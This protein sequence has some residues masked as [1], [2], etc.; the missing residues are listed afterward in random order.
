MKI[1]P[2]FGFAA[3]ALA[4]AIT[5]SGLA[6]Q[7]SSPAQLRDQIQESFSVSDY[8]FQRLELP[9]TVS[10][11]FATR[12]VIAGRTEVIQARPHS[13][14]GMDYQVFVD[15]GGDQLEEIQAPEPA[16]FLGSIAGDPGSKVAGTLVDGQ[17]QALVW[18]SDGST[19]A[20]QPL[21]E[22]DPTADPSMHIVY[23][24]ADSLPGDWRC[25]ELDAPVL[26]ERLGGDLLGTGEHWCELAFDTDVEFFVKNG[27][28]VPNTINDVELIV[29]L[30]NVI[31]QRDVDVIFDAAS[32]IVRTS[33]PD[34]YTSTNPNNLLNSF[35]GHWASTKSFIKRDIAHLMTGKNVDGSTIG[36]AY[37]S[38]VCSQ[39]QGFGL[40]QSRFTTN[41]NLRAGLTA[42]EIG[43]NFSAQHCDGHGAQCF[44]MCS[45]LGGCGGDVTKFGTFEIAQIRP[46]AAARPCCPELAP[47]LTFPLFDSFEAVL[48]TD[49]WPSV[50]GAATSTAAT[51]EVNGTQSLNLDTLNAEDFGDDYVRSNYILMSGLSG[52][53]ISFHSEHVGV[54]A[55]ETLIV[56]Y[57]NNS[58]DWQNAVTVV[59]DGVTQTAF[60]LHQ[61]DLPLNAYHDGFRVSFRVNGSSSDD[62]WYVD[63]FAVEDGCPTPLNYCSTSP[64]SVG[65]GAIMYWNGSTSVSANNLTISASICPAGQ[66]GIFFYGPN[67]TQTVFGNGF[68]CAAGGITR[69]QVQT[70]DIFGEAALAFDVT[71]TG[72]SAGDSQNFQFWYRDPA[73]GGAFFNLSDG[74]ETTWCP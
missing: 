24:A 60:E 8:S 22:A 45:G 18:P 30:I 62:D 54:E 3:V 74:L 14:R 40:S 28:S 9:A 61:F 44:I 17:L 72:I 41:L 4:A 50:Q 48:D 63:A 66:A 37:L 31:Y 52:K 21:T 73:G 49:I 43:H 12:V 67:Q 2:P 34:P 69:M 59:S 16:T 39:S 7:A 71:G 35:R 57:M 38:V 55:G 53:R 32:I 64:N 13:V 46:Y 36:I 20:I 29:S 23:D 5:P 42:H 33:E 70:I 58:G 1:R 15:R 6:A 26:G 56:E 68:I 65:S 25:I 19:W 10:D 51:G 47:A 11:G 27:S